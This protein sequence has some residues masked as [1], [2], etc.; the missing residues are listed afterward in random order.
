[1][2][3]LPGGVALLAAAPVL[4]SHYKGP[5]QGYLV[6]ARYLDVA[7][8][9]YLSELYG[10]TLHVCA[11]QNS[12][13]PEFVCPGCEPDLDVALYL[14]SLNGVEPTK[15]VIRVPHMV[16]HNRVIS[17]RYIMFGSL[18]VLYVLSC[19]AAALVLRWMVLRRLNTLAGFV[20]SIRPNECRAERLNLGGSDELTLLGDAVN[21]M[22][23]DMARAQ[24]LEKKL[25]GAQKMQALGN[26]AVGIAHDFNNMLYAIVGYLSMLK[27]RVKDDAVSGEYLDRIGK[28][29]ELSS[30]LVRQLMAFGRSDE[31]GAIRFS[32]SAVIRE[33][34]QL[35]QASLPST[36]RIHL[37]LQEGP[38]SVV[39]DP[40]KIYQMMINLFLNALHAMREKG[41]VITVTTGIRV[42]QVEQE[43]GLQPKTVSRWLCITVA[44]TGCGIPASHLERVFDPYFSTKPV[45]DGGGLG[46]SVV[47]HIVESAGG[48]IE[49]DSQEGEGSV[50]SIYFP[51][52]EEAHYHPSAVQVERSQESSSMPNT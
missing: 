18:I 21:R 40:T 23:E 1:V 16:M 41:G 8:Q 42:P 5:P 43:A 46:L 19:G 28:A 20:R 39:A 34:V 48:V 26:L 31:Q 51:L 3:I 38:D 30:N 33:S 7:E 37:Q 12:G 6:M 50:F 49:V 4:T 11:G 29:V 22:L 2:A 17:D 27:P 10:V 15:V 9:A 14:R 24:A 32:L 36:I 52:V 45:E 44:D 47:H 35:F 13:A 25:R